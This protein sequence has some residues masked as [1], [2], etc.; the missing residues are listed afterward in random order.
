M[1][2]SLESS[3]FEKV[4]IKESLVYKRVN[5]DTNGWCYSLKKVIEE[6]WMPEMR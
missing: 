4:L 6:L 3:M 1:R 2:H 5:A